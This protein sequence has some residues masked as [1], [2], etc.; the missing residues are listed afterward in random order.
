MK[1]LPKS[2][3][4]AERKKRGKEIRDSIKLKEEKRLIQLK[5]LINDD[6]FLPGQ[7]KSF[8]QEDGKTYFQ[9]IKSTDIEKA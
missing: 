2:E 7:Q 1:N 4:I 6:T 3:K 8:D 9:S 5:N